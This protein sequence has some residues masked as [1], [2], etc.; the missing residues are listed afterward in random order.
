MSWA[1]TQTTTV[2]EDKVYCLLSIYRVFLP[3]IYSEG[4]TYATMRLRE[5]IERRQ[6]G[7]GIERL[8]DLSGAS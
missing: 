2:K 5:E 8:H 7:Q 4:E 3:L 1:A 6:E